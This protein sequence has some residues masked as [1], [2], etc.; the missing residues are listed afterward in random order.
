[1]ILNNHRSRNNVL[2]RLF[3][4]M[5]LLALVLGSQAGTT[6]VARA[7]TMT[8]SVV[9]A[10][11]GTPV[12]AYKYIINIDNTGSTAQ[13]SPEPGTGCSPQDA[14]YPDSCN[15]TSIAGVP[16]SSPI[17]TQ[18]D[19]SDFASGNFSLPDGRYLISVLADGYKLDGKHFTVAGG[20]VN[21]TVELQPFPLPDA[22]IQAAVF[23]DIS[24]VNSAPDLPAEHGLAGFQGHI[25]DYL[26]E[27]TTDVYGA[28]LCG[29]GTCLSA[30]YVVSGGVDVGTVAPIDAAGRCPSPVD[31]AG[32]SMIGGGTAPAGSVIE[33]KIKIPNLGPN[34]YALSVTPPDGSGWIQT[35][36]LEGNHD[37]D[38]WVMEGSTGLDTEFVIGGE[39]FPGIIFGYVPH[40]GTP[41][42]PGLATNLGGSG[43]IKGVVEAVKIYVP[44]TG[45]VPGL[46]GQIWGGLQGAKI[47][48]PIEYPWV[49][50]TNLGNGDT[51]VWVGQGD[52]NGNFTIP[53]VPA[54]TYT[55]TWWDEPQNTILDLVNV[56]VGAGET[57][58]MGI[59][60]LTGWW[61]F[62]DG[63][64]FNDD[65]RNG[66]KDAG[67]AGLAGY[68]LTMR[69]R[70]NSL[71]DRGTTVATTD[72]DGYYKFEAAYP[73]TQWLVME[74]YDDLHYT[75]GVTYQADN[76]PDPTTILGAGVDVS[77][78]PIIGLSGRM[79]WG[80]HTYDATGAGGVD[81]RNGGIVG[82]VSYDT[83]RNE[84]D[85]RYAAVEDWQPS[86][87]NLTVKLFEPVPCG[88]TIGAACDPTERYELASDGS[89]AKGTLLNSYLT[90][91][92]QRPTGCIARGLDGTP[93]VHGI[94]EQVLPL[95]DSLGCIEAPLMGVQFAP[96]ETDQG[97]PDANFGAA[98]DGNYGFGDGCF[99][100]TLDATDPSAP[101]CVG[102]TFETLPGGRDY[103]VQ[104]EIPNDALGRPMY[105]V[106]REEDIN[107]GNGDEF[108]PAV[109]PS[110]CAGP[111]HTVDSTGNAT[112]P[113][114]PGTSPY[115][116][117]QKPLCDTKLVKLS[118]G[119]SIA[120][121]F[122]LFTD[123][124]LPGRF[125]F[126]MIDDLNFS[127]NPKSITYGEKAGMPFTPVG[128]YDYTNRL[129][130]TVETDYNGLADVL[131][132]SSNRINC[133]T[134]SGVCANL[135]R[136]VGND[137]G[138]PGKL[139]LNYNPRFR[140]I[141]AE[142]EALP[143][144][145][146]PADLAPT[147]VGV[148]VQLPGGQT[149]S[150][151]ACMLDAAT[152]QI[153]AVSVPY[154][155]VSNN[156]QRSFTISGQGFGAT[157]GTG[158]VTL[159]GVNLPTT[160]WSNT[161]I[162]VT[163]PGTT[164]GGPQQLKVTAANGQTTIN[165][166]TFHVI[167]TTGTT[168]E[169]YNPPILTVGPGALA[170][171][172][173]YRPSETLPAAANHA[174][175]NAL[176]DAP[177]GAL[178]VVYPND[179]AGARQ[180][181]RGAYYENLIIT[182]PVKLQGV[183]PGSPDG[184]VRGSIIDG[185]AFAG[186]SP[187]FDDWYTRIATATWDGNQTI[188][189]G[190]DISLFLSSNAFPTTYS[191]YTAPSI[192][193]FDLRGGDQQ[194]FPGNI[195]AIGGGPTG[196]PGGLITQ[197]GAIFANGYA[198]NLQITNNVVQNNGGAYGTIR[199]GTPDLPAPDTNN[200]NEG[201][202]IANN[203]IIQNAGT[204][205]AG[206]I[207]L[208]N[209]ADSYQVVRNDICGNFSS[210]Y[211]GGVSAVG[212]S[213][214]GTIRD[215]RIYF[216]ESFDEGGG[217]MI[218]GAL[219]ADTTTLSPG[220]GPVDIYN[221]LIQANMSND[222][223]GGL[224]F[225]MAGNFPM[226]VYNNMI[227][228]NI[229]T[230]EGGGIGINDTPNVMFYNNTVMKNLTTATA[231][232]S[233]GAAAPA[234]LSTS[235]NSDL[236]QATLPAGSPNFSDPLLF[237]NIFW[238]NRAGTRNLSN[239]TGLSVSD[240]DYWDLGV[241]DN[242]GALL[243]PTNSIVQQNAG[244]HSYTTSA[245]NSTAD[246]SVAATYDVGVTFNTWRNNPA[247]LGAIM[248]SA[249]LPPNLMGNY[250]ITAASPAYNTGAATK[251]Q[252][253][254]QGGGNRAAPTTDID[255]DVRPQSISGPA[256][257]DM[258]ADE[259]RA[260]TANLGITKTDG[261]TSV[262][263]GQQVTYTITVTNAGPDAVNGATVTDTMPAALTGV[264]WTCAPASS[265]GAASG[266]G[267]INTTVS[268]FNGS[269]ATFTVTG[270]LAANATGSLVNTASVV[271]P[272]GTT[273]PTTGTPNSA[274]DTDAIVLPVDLQ[275]TKTDGLTSVNRGAAVRYTIVV[276][277]A[278][279]NAVTGANVNDSFPN[280]L[281]GTI[282]WT[283]TTTGGA[284]CGGGS[285][286]GT[287]NR[288]VNMPVGSTIT[289][290]TT[291]G[292]VSTTTTATSLANTATVTA[293]AN[294]LDTNTANN[295]ATDTTSIVV[296]SPPTLNVLDNFNRADAVN[297][298]TNWSQ[299][300]NNIRL[301]SNN[302]QHN[303]GSQGFAYWNGTTAGGPTFGSVQGAAFTLAN[304]AAASN[305]GNS[306]ILKATGG[307]LTAPTNFIRVRVNGNTDRIMVEF[308]TNSG[309]SYTQIGSFAAGSNVVSGDTLTARVNADGSVDVWR[310]AAYL[311]RSSTSAFTGTG[312]IGIRLNNNGRVDNF[313][314]GTL[315]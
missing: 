268:L 306:L 17:Y 72:A 23:E 121:A 204:N 15:W 266:S 212:Y 70:E 277:N 29:T 200:H 167:K 152:P 10:V 73:M 202:V 302:A 176:D 142:F 136:F 12:G 228:N 188:Y 46:P 190:A 242:A 41:S 28:P 61:T 53:N 272:S 68:T 146:V 32:L 141:A 158:Q 248:I 125:W 239:V 126:I 26:G 38:A 218:A 21:V 185:G 203:R 250:H 262:V 261:Q 313:S 192:D 253:S 84:L 90:E 221:N 264:T 65:N 63:Y 209:G 292:S 184:S 148:T 305:N 276:T 18:G 95:N 43:T 285:G 274:T 77:V 171:N 51:V 112:F 270:T 113:G 215:N 139:N 283:C 235:V 307:T 179:P 130:T 201:V 238:D 69:K 123:V 88:T 189:D 114:G 147:Q 298:G 196:L 245:T 227:V 107:I 64:V 304:S 241:A 166:L 30:C 194:G 169:R 132:P 71:M 20:A 223:G 135:Y 269:S 225:L 151:V 310:N 6:S 149:T 205:Q 85:P 187:V 294:R 47:D 115:E 284:T 137:P 36:T 193:G 271:A 144:L 4:T 74:A 37:W 52:V 168:A 303:A 180:N 25:T 128:I 206:G 240:A 309:G 246:P 49:T 165:G 233:N 191:A 199:I 117:T 229:S 19:Q 57:V 172:A 87:P 312:R 159:N 105:K 164:I 289:F 118:N 62:F 278:G 58:D 14:G 98:V 247:F 76:Q 110:E 111:L 281:N 251:A 256:A 3:L 182:K 186:D 66:I 315:P 195:N 1:M 282:N 8:L 290:T 91:T 143:G 5:T 7:A 131:L 155:N 9:S 198:R 16:G 129:I 314:G 2:Y 102:G 96:Y 79:D 175:Q 230:H 311:G 252:P 56:T 216:N 279:P 170:S 59:L 286:S 263:A 44:T 287:I 219:P 60:P 122:N 275:I 94:D 244:T 67:E 174:I 231:V 81:P 22:Q 101:L 39:P 150:P 50:L 80:K 40:P 153:Y 234:G 217:I 92:W 257:F 173:R 243:S 211:G 208:F 154:A 103:L 27:V 104:V 35:T 222:D 83:T 297:L 273:D 109:P 301:N 140:T 280:Q 100:G 93:L 161:Q 249:D 127:S 183:G 78:H 197:G 124:P 220:S 237:N 116:G 97:T 224:R 89:Y 134:P 133:P 181:P 82:T 48:K 308:T 108:V 293:P 42:D 177:A 119:K 254:Y 11:D 296:V 258:G 288:T 226:N 299:P 120:P 255:G 260:N 55:L 24:P 160:S 162:A 31:A 213:P 295:S 99:N 163:V 34:R 236:L 138:V 106:T 214:N 33:G 86:I 232:T 54:G 300:N 265:C 145:L 267:S 210:E 178:V 291:S 156:T 45:G 157:K 259:V 13:R 207:G 75:T